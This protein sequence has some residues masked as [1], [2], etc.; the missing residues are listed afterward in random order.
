MKRALYVVAAAMLVALLMLVAFAP[1]FLTAEG[2]PLDDAWIH[3]VYARSLARSATLSY[4]PGI[5]ATGSTS[6]LWDFFLAAPQA[7]ASTPQAAVTLTKLLGLLLHGLGALLLCRALAEGKQPQG[8]QLAGAG[9]VAI[10]PDLV[11]AAVSGMEIPLA[12]LMAAALLYGARRAR[13][14]P[15]ALLCGIA[16]LARPELALLCFAIPFALFARRDRERLRSTLLAAF[17]GTAASFG[18]V[19]LRNL[20]VSDRPLPATFYAKVGQMPIGIFASQ[21]VGFR[22]LLGEIAVTD[23][24]ILLVALMLITGFVLSQRKLADD[25]AAAAA[26]CAIA[27]V[28]F[29]LSFVLIPPFDPGAFYHQRYVLPALPLMVGALPLLMDLPMRHWLRPS[30]CR[31]GRLALLGFLFAGLLIDS[32]VRYPRLSNDARNI[33]DLQVAMGQALRA[34]KPSDIVWVSDAG[35]IRYF[36]NAFV[37]DLIGL[38]SPAMLGANAQSFLDSHRPRYLQLVEGWVAVDEF[39]QRQLEKRLVTFESTTAYTVTSFAKMSTEWLARCPAFLPPGHIFVRGKH[40]P[41]AC[42]P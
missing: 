40:F 19:A 16:P 31:I 27:L 11:S 20:S 32:A 26:A 28:Y 1:E 33:D 39:T 30:H 14:I 18:L 9:L 25:L 3:A 7:I 4:N 10:H 23:S 21:A 38:N 8:L 17:C 5:P 15:F 6:P 29:V 37:V 34:A 42:A 13:A 22:R 24:S 36:G 2:Y 12:A 41:F 35:A